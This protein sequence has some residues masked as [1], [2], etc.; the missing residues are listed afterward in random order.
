[1][2]AGRHAFWMISPRICAGFD[3]EKAVLAF[4]IRNRAPGAEKIGIERRG[5]IIAGV[6]VPPGGVGLP[7]LDE[8]LA[9]R[10]AVFIEH[11]ARY[12][13]PLAE[14]FT[15]EVPRQIV[16]GF[17][18]RIVPVHR[19][20]DFRERVRQRNGGLRGRPPE[21]RFVVRIGV[22]RLGAA[23]QWWVSFIDSP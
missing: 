10:P 6:A 20:R 5:M 4:I 9:H 11:P 13:D 22:V 16:V 18:Q 14:R 12:D 1:M 7:H 21:G 15:G 17:A 3:G 23:R 2:C 8:R 19:T